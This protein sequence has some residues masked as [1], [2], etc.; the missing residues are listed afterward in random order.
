MSDATLSV[1][2]FEEQRVTELRTAQSKAER[3]FREIEKS[4]LIRSGISESRLNEEIYELAKEMYGTTTY[5]AQT[6]CPRGQE[7]AGAICRE[8]PT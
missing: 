8:P 1:D 6:Y 3:L 5:L 7:H 4:G 2:A